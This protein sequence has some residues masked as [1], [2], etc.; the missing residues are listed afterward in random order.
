MLVPGFASIRLPFPYDAPAS[1]ASPT[2]LGSSLTSCTGT[3]F[4]FQEGKPNQH[5]YD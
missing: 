4:R 3:K 1:I 5:G 2:A